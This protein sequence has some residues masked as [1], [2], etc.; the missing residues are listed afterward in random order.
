M[1]H[2]AGDLSQ[3]AGHTADLLVTVICA[4]VVAV[5]AWDRYNTPESNRVS[6]TRA[7][8]LFTGAGYVSTSLILFLL[9][10]KVA[11]QPGLLTPGVLDRKSVV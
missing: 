7:A 1:E 4:V 8:F 10:S 6:T 3:T 9:I 2:P 11:L 5:H